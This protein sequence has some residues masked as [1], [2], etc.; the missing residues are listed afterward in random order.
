MTDEKKSGNPI[1]TI[2][3]SIGGIS[4]LIVVIIAVF[5]S[6]NMQTAGFI[7]AALALMGIV[8]GYF[9]SKQQ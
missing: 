7:V 5:A 2:A 1:V 9:A 3:T 6:E 8:L 4:V